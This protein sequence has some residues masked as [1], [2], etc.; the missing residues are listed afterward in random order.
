MAPPQ[1]NPEDRPVAALVAPDILA[2]LE[3]SPSDVAAET[4]EMHPADLADVVELLPSERVSL[5]LSALPRERAADVLEYLN[6]ELRAEILEAM[7]ARQA[8]ELVSE[9]TP[10]DR[11][12]TLEELS[13]I[14]EQRAEEIVSEMPT[15]ARRETEQLLRFDPDTAGGLMTTDYV[16]IYPHRTAEETIHKI[17]EIAPES[18]FIYYLYVLDKDEQLLGALSLRALLLAY[19]K[20]GHARSRC[21]DGIELRTITEPIAEV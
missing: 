2:L 13:E 11:A 16:W 17:R 20:A 10:D 8:A 6:E 12:D 7:S 21:R 3:E 4:E 14:S 15:E 18:E 1:R 9:M 5:F 19:G